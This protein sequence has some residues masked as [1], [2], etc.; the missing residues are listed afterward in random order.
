[1]KLLIALLPF[2][3]FT[4]C[5]SFKC[6]VEEVGAEGISKAVIVALE[7]KNEDAVER[8]IIGAV[9]ALGLCDMPQ[10]RGVIAEAIC[11]GVGHAVAS[12]VGSKI[13]AEWECNPEK[14]KEGLAAVVTKGCSLL[15][16]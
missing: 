14:A 10:S 6:K 16:F 15:P 8:D 11:P 1:M 3:F 5:T 13:P 9:K 7:C 12:I 4:A 2:L